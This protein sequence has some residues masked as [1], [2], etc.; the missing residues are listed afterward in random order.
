MLLPTPLK[1]LLSTPKQWQRV[2]TE[3]Q[4]HWQNTDNV[5]KK[6]KSLKKDSH[7]KSANLQIYIEKHIIMKKSFKTEDDYKIVKL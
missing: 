7:E 1:R 5:K 4:W 3:N 6:K 2:E